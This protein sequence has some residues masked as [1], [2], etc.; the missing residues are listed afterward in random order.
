MLCYSLKERVNVLPI[1]RRC[2]N[3]VTEAQVIHKGQS[4]FPRDLSLVFHIGEVADQVFNDVC[5][6]V[7]LDLVHPGGDGFKGLPRS[8]VKHDEDGVA[9]LVEDPCDGSERFLACG[10]PY[11]KLYMCFVFDYH[12]EVSKLNANG[13]VVLFVEKVSD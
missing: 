12:A 3:I 13:H 8:E 4:F 11:L 2:L 10:V 6:G 7:L 5:I 9:T 1:Q